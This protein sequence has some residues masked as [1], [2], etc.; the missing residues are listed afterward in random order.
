MAF[1]S[2]ISYHVFHDYNVNIDCGP[3]S[4]ISVRKAQWCKIGVEPNI[5]KAKIEIRKINVTPEGE[6]PLKG[7]SMNE[8]EVNDLTVGLAEAGFGET[9]ELL[10]TISKR[11]N[12]KDTVENIDK[13]P[14]DESDGELFDMRSLLLGLA[15]NDN[16]EE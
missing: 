14:D 13:D 4:Y 10:K 12:F 16:E 11:D 3:S 2:N 5:D 8:K 6:T 15:D 7:V 1:D 9:K